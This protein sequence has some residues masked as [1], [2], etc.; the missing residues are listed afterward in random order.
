MSPRVHL[1]DQE[2]EWSPLNCAEYT[3]DVAAGVIEEMPAKTKVCIVGAGHGAK[4]APLEDPEWSVWA[5]NTVAPFDS[6]GRVRADRWFELHQRCAQSEDDMRWLAK[7]PIPCYVPPDLVNVNPMFVRFPLEKLEVEFG[8]YWCCTFAY[9]I[10][11]AMHEGIK[12]IGLYGVELAYGTERERTV[13]WANVS[14]WMG[15]G[16]SR[17][18]RFWLPHYSRLGTHSH[19][20]GLDYVAEKEQTEKYIELIHAIDDER[21][22]HDR[23]LEGM[24]G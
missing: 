23:A 5:L 16:E 3:L 7:C 6:K 1:A 22:K 20:Y 8:T 17:G 4:E 12:D 2:I 21:E 11:L 13:E 18:V 10:A 14:W 9:Q 19:R 24:G 15:F